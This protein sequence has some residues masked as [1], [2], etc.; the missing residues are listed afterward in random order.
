MDWTNLLCEMRV[1]ELFGGAPSSKVSSEPRREFERDYGRAIFSTPVRRLQD[2]AQV[3]P[4][5]PSDVVRT[6]LTHSQE[7]SSV[8]RDMGRIAARWLMGQE[9]IRSHDQLQDIEAIAATCGIIHDL[10]NPPFGHSGEGAIRDWFRKKEAEDERFLEFSDAESKLRQ[11]QLAADF[12]HF[13]GNA[14]TIR[15]VSKLQVLT[16][17]HGLNLTCGTLSAVCKYT[18]ASDETDGTKQETKKPGYFAS[19]NELMEKVRSKTGTGPARN[20][21]TYLVEAADDIVYSTVDIEDAVKKGV[22]TWDEVY[23]ELKAVVDSS[24]FDPVMKN[25]NDYISAGTILKS[26]TTGS[27]WSL[28]GEV[29]SQVFRTFA[30]ICLVRSTLDAFKENYDAIIA[31]DYHHELIEDCTAVSLVKTC[32]R[33]AKTKVYSHPEILRREVAGQRVIHDLMDMFWEG[34]RAF[35]SELDTRTYNGKLNLLMSPN[36]RIV[37]QEA[38]NSSGLPEKYCKMQLVTDYIC[39]MTD[40]YACT[41]HKQLTNG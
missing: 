28:R 26:G 31:G 35:P 12:R 15:L 2:K 27:D 25:V 10:G 37:C 16:D 14:Q 29:Y 34:A 17:L 1:R 24:I 4:S 20:P 39:G 5:D 7:V 6:R 11:T 23:E 21:V 30:I 33:I 13:E 32:Q 3:F 40:S 18:A 22:I 8:S 36:Y 38:L 9:H 41:L 19:E